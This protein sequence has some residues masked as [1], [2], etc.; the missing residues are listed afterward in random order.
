[1]TE[2]KVPTNST[3]AS[4]IAG[5]QVQEAV[6]L[7]VGREDLLALRNEAYIYTG[8]TLDSYKS[9]YT[10][11]EW[12]PTHDHYENIQEWVPQDGQT[13][14]DLLDLTDVNDVSAIDFEPEMVLTR[15]CL[16][17]DWADTTITPL[18]ALGAGDGKCPDCRETLSLDVGRSF[19]VDDPIVDLPVTELGLPTDDIITLRSQLDRYHYT[20]RS[21]K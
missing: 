13:L 6:K 11:D 5:I 19:K 18:T 10:E 2:G 16:S 15:R 21:Q 7:L 12:C 9:G 8:D 4:I 1:M 14:R 17:C 3:S 20:L